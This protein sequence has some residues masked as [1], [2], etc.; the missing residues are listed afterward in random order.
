[1]KKKID[2]FKGQIEKN[3]LIERFLPS[4]SA[5]QCC[6]VPGNEQ[7][8]FI[9]GHLQENGFDIKPIMAPSVSEGKERLRFCLHSYNSMQEISKCLTVLAKFI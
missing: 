7:V 6:L 9:A 5:I 8:K 3:G 1:L 4:D 2:F